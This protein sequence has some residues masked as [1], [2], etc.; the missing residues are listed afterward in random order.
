MVESDQIETP[1]HEMP[2]E[3][4]NAFLVGGHEVNNYQR[5]A[6]ENKPS[7]IGDT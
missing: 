2:K 4:I 3:D 6:P 1:M 5:P 7:D